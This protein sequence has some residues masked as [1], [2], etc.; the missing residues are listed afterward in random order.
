VDAEFVSDPKDIQRAL[1]RSKRANAEGR[2]YLIEVL[3]ERNGIGG[4]SEWHPPFSIASLRSRR[5]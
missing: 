4:A 1:K 2:A 5:V 3:V